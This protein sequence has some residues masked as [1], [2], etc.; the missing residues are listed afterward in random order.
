MI[1]VA[2][3]VEGELNGHAVHEP[4]GAINESANRHSRAV[5]SMAQSSS[6]T[7]LHNIQRSN[8]DCEAPGLDSVVVD[9]ASALEASLAFEPESAGALTASSLHTLYTLTNTQDARTLTL[10]PTH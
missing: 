6:S 2:V 1:V 3:D 8:A 5:D 4:V 7:L 10:A 9:A